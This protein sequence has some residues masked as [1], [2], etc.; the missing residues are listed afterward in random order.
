[1][2]VKSVLLMFL[3]GLI[4]YTGFAYNHSDLRPNS[5][6]DD[7]ISQAD[8]SSISGIEVKITLQISSLANV[9]M[10]LSNAIKLNQVFQYN[11]GFFE[12]HI[13]NDVGKYQA[14]KKLSYLYISAQHKYAN[15]GTQNQA[16]LYKVKNK[17]QYWKAHLT[18]SPRDSLSLC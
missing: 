3:I 13:V 5:K 7:L 16:N 10:E 14:N 6:V 12:R 8:S 4:S 9:P 15:D 1:M 18:R 11:Q 17:N 2:K